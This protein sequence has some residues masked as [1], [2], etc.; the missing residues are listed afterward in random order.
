MLTERNLCWVAGVGQS[1]LLAINHQGI[2]ISLHSSIVLA[3]NSVLSMTNM[4]V[5]P[6]V[7]LQVPKEPNS[8][9]ITHTHVRHKLHQSTTQTSM[10]VKALVPL[11]WCHLDLLQDQI[12][13]PAIEHSSFS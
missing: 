10:I 9:G 4:L 8:A 1:N 13:S 11:V 12:G 7:R 6:H 2:T 3:M 5:T